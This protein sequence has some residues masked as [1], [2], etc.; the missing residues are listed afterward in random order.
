MS[1]TGQLINLFPRHD[2]PIQQKHED[3]PSKY[4]Q[5]AKQAKPDL[6]S[7]INH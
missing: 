2:Q 3:N 7:Q 4:D 1:P 5:N 6:K